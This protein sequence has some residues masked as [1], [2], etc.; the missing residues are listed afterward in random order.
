MK[1]FSIEEFACPLTG[2][3]DMD[4]DFLSMLDKARGIAG[5]PFVITSGFRS[6]EHNKS[7]GGKPN[8]AHL[9]GYAADIAVPNSRA[10]FTI[11]ESLIKAGFTR[12]GVANS[13]IHV[14]SDPSKPQEVMWYYG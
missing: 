3:A 1:Y 6:V 12:I 8:S 13:F 14:D 9:Y 5:I 4:A 2:E 7:V 10:R 11:I